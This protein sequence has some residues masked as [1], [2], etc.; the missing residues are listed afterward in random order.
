MTV[1]GTEQLAPLLADLDRLE[2]PAEIAAQ[3]I[4]VLEVMRELERQVCA[5]RDEAVVGLH[6]SGLSLQG[7]ADVTGLS[8]GRVH[9]IVQRERGT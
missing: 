9:Q 3:A 8:R 1:A 7:V 2:E 5:V 6:R 4:R